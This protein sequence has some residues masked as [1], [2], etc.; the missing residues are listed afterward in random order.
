MLA[1]NTA[2]VIDL[3][4]CI[5]CLVVASNEERRTI[6]LALGLF[7]LFASYNDLAFPDDWDIVK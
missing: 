4:H 1:V 5:L 2:L 7:D 3:R 6:R